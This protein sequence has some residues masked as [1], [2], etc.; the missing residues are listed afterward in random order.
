MA[1][2]DL[3]PAERIAAG[4]VGRP[5][6]RRFYL[7]VVAGGVRH[8]MLAE[9]QQIAALAEQGVEILA[10]SEVDVDGEAV[11]RLIEEGLDI[12]EA[13]D[14]RFRIGSIA[15]GIDRSD[16]VSLT[17][18][19]T[20]EGEGVTFIVAPEQFVAMAEVA[21]KAVAGGRPICRWCR[22][23]MD[24]DGHACPARN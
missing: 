21:L 10:R 13:S 9:K 8:L 20:D 17:V 23:P 5:G 22:L 12:D 1:I 16:L 4:A 3:G 2:D 18:E 6:S 11:D 19:S 7:E 15:M 24:P 14:E